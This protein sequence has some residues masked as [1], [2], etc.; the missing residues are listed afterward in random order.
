MG[1]LS[2]EDLGLVAFTCPYLALYFVHPRHRPPGSRQPATDMLHQANNQ[3]LSTTLAVD[4][5]PIG[6]QTQQQ[7]S[8]AGQGGAGAFTGHCNNINNKLNAHP[9]VSIIHPTGHCNSIDG[10]PRQSGIA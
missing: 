4:C 6:S 9:I 3:M 1:A 5:D 8:R 7:E 2:V 10:Q